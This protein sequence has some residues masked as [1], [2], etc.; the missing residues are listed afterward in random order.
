MRE[1]PGEFDS[2]YCFWGVARR[3]GSQADAARRLEALLAL[4]PDDQKARLY[5]GLVA[6]DRG[7]PRGLSLLEQAA[8]GFGRQ[9][10][11]TGESYARQ[12]LIR[13]HEKE[14]RR[15]DAERELA[16]LTASA[17]RSG[18]PALVVRA[19]VQQGWHAQS[20]GDYGQAYLTF[21]HARALLAPEMPPDLPR[22]VLDGLAANAFSLG[23]LDE[24]AAAYREELALL[25]ARGDRYT[26]A[27]VRLWLWYADAG[28]GATREELAAAARAALEVARASGNRDAE[29]YALLL[30]GRTASDPDARALLPAA[31][32]LARAQGAGRAEC[33]ALADLGALLVRESPADPGRGL[34]LFDEAIACTRRGAMADLGV[35]VLAAKGVALLRLGRDDEAQRTIEA[36]FEALEQLRGRQP[37]PAL[38]TRV[39]ARYEPPFREAAGLLLERAR[40]GAGGPALAAAF[41]IVERLRRGQLLER[42][43]AAE[44]GGASGPLPGS[45]AGPSP[46]ASA[47]AA[48]HDAVLL[49][50]AAVQRRLLDPASGVDARADLFRALDELEAKEL[51]LRDREAREAPGFHPEHAPL[52]PSLEAVQRALASDEAMIYFLVDDRTPNRGSGSWVVAIYRGGAFVAPVPDRFELEHR[53]AMLR[54]LVERR[55]GSEADGAAALHADLLGP[56]LAALPRGTRR[57]VLVPD[58]PL[59]GLPF[60]ALRPAP[61][62]PPLAAEYEVVIAPSAAV[63]REA[64]RRPA[65]PAAGVLAFG[66]PELPQAGAS[67]SA[68][69][70][71]TLLG[72]ATLGRL[73]YAHEEL[74]G[75]RRTLGGRV[76]LREGSAATERAVKSGDL[77]SLGLLHFAAH[78]MVEER[79]PERSAIVLGAGAADEDGLLQ[80]RE[81]AALP[82]SGRVVVLSACRSATGEVLA[83][84]GP[85]GLAHA[86]FLAGARAVVG[87]LWPVRDDEVVPLVQA[88]YQRLARGEALGAA[89]AGARRDRLAAGAP[90]AA[91]AG[92]VILGD[93]DWVPFPGGLP[94][95]DA[96]RARWAV[97]VL[98]AAAAL[99]AA[100]VARRR[101]QRAAGMVDDQP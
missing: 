14:G 1:R 28:R 46:R 8:D 11:A 84:E 81:I 92:F 25:Q 7:E 24:S 6:S 61:G 44:D 100:A 78:A 26:E 33:G 4:R 43:A 36:A 48:A 37:D 27:D 67:P 30:C 2:Y 72:A 21:R 83:G 75:M 51:E 40:G 3:D 42:M 80:P 20:V 58:G 90:A 32:E 10:D 96:P 79:Q 64:A 52:L 87:S 63:W 54:A 101:M 49:E 19:A 88:F 74:A 77:A 34:A 16:L 56:A 59:F 15:G 82:L 29:A 85:V 73:P 60:D 69:R 76:T 45:A 38:R 71:W 17:E 41:D 91:W 18:D 47:A 22:M 31:V 93:G 66:D 89:L 70:D 97:L 98:L 39:A 13:L 12:S 62:V 65:P 94:R 55:D 23:R 95:D 50:I 99:L 35:E 86:F 68:L 53:I 57:L 5:L 9:G